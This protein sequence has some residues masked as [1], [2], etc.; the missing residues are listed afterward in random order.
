[1]NILFWTETF[2]PRIGG[3]E[4]ISGE[5]IAGLVK[6]NHQFMIVT[7]KET[8]GQSNRERFNGMDI[9]RFPF[10]QVLADR[11]LVELKALIPEV[12]MLKQSFRPDLIHIHTSQP[13]LFFHHHTREAWSSPVLFTVHEPPE[14]PARGNHTLIK[15]VLSSTDWV[16]AVSGYTLCQ[17]R[18]DRG[19]RA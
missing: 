8:D 13:S 6:R 10:Q 17:A 4:I 7:S 14:S 15:R 1:M 5:L 2:W 16:T 19:K 9:R 3:V 11:S 12:A 18:L